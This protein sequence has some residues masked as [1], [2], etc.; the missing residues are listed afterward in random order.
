MT[1]K[2]P[3]VPPA[4]QSHKGPGS[5]QNAPLDRTPHNTKR[6]QNP[7]KTGQQANTKQN[8]THQGGRQDR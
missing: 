5:Q 3:P 4:N 8:T 7:D 1:S 2:A 6:D